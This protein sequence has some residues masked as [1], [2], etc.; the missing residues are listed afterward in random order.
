MEVKMFRIP[1]FHKNEVSFQE[2]WSIM[3]SYGLGDALA[4]MKGMT[5]AWDKYIANQNAFFNNEVQV[6][7]FEN[8]DEF[9]EYYSNEVNAYNAVF[10]NLKPLFA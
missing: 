8:D 2:G 7:A 4:G 10:S 5:N 3:K 9:F 1:N 6:L